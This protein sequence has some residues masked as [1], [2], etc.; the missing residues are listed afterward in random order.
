MTAKKIGSGG[1]GNVYEGVFHGKNVAMKFTPIEIKYELIIV[2]AVSELEKNISEY[3]MQLATPGSGV[4]V[5]EAFF[6]QQNQKQDGNGKWVAENYNIF[7]YPRYDCNL[8]ELHTEN[9]DK[10]TEEVM[11]DIFDQCFNRNDC[12]KNYFILVFKLDFKQPFC[13]KI[14]K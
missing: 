9:F 8:Y 1:F 6:R 4:L 2:K 5:P 10:F 13:F 14:S 12:L 3:R 7:I 11:G